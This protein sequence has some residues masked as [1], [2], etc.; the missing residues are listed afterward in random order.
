MPATTVIVSATVFLST[1]SHMLPFQDHCSS[2]RAAEARV[3][4][5]RTARPEQQQQQRDWQQPGCSGLSDIPQ[6]GAAGL[7]ARQRSEPAACGALQVAQ[8]LHL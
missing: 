4:A 2:T 1:F 8:L 3:H 7:L 6:G 5:Q